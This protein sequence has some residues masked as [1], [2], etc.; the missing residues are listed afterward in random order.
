MM[1]QSNLYDIKY[2]SRDV[3]CIV[4][5]MQYILYI[6][7]GVFPIDIYQSVDMDNKD[8]LVMVFKRSDTAQVYEKWKNYELE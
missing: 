1:I 4:N 2:N 3:V 7:N 8:I 5:Y 6:K